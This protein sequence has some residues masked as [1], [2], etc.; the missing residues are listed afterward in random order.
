MKTIFNQNMLI[1][2]LRHLT[3]LLCPIVF[4][5]SICTASEKELTIELIKVKRIWDQGNH[6]AFTGLTRY[7]DKFFCVFREGQGHVSPEGKI[8]VLS[9]PDGESWKSE[10]L[11][12]KEGYDLRD[13]KITVTPGGKR[14]MINGGAAIREGK[15]TE[16]EFHSFV[17]FSANGKDWEPIEWVFQP[18]RW[19]WRVTWFQEKAYGVAYKVGARNRST[20]RFGTTLI[21]SPDGINYSVLVEELYQEGGPTEATLR[22][23]D[24]GTC[25]C[26]HRRDGKDT[27]TALVGKSQPLYKEWSWQDLGLY[28]GGP[29]FIK[30]PNGQWIAAGRIFTDDGAKTILCQLDVETGKLIQKLTLP[31]GGDTS[32]P[33]L[34]W[35]DDQLWVSYY[36]SHEGKT[37][38]YFAQISVQ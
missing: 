12:V 35:Y 29:N 13:P 34:V 33:G 25:Y 20:R 26:L 4:L 21:Q 31:S 28:Y 23:D 10:A 37:S 24:D 5:C 1:P 3:T 36:S 30:L 32:Y 15:K 16:Q 27:R 8:R 7:Q 6:N 22:F 17:T 11:L 2:I 14:L 38:I 18:N 9:S 19:L